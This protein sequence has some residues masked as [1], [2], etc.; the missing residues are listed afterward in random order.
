LHK[1]YD[2]THLHRISQTEWLADKLKIRSDE[3]LPPLADD[4]I[5]RVGIKIVGVYILANAIPGLVKAVSEASAHGLWTGRLTAIETKI[6]PA[7]LQVALALFLAIRTERVL[8]LLAKG[9]KAQGKKIVIG[10]LVILAIL[11][12][13]GRGLAIHPW[14]QP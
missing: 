1:D 14:L 6:I 3:Q 12:L 11:I 10:S 13:L 5:L 9:E 7:V 8:G 2:A 4:A